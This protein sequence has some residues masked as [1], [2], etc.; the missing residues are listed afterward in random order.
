V[1]SSKL[2]SLAKRVRPGNRH[3]NKDAVLQI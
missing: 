2:F 3:V 1:V